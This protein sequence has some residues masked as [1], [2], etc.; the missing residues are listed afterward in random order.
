M[1]K[2]YTAYFYSDAEWASTAIEA[3][4]PVAALAA[5]CKMNDEDSCIL[6]FW[7]YDEAC[8]V[9]H[10]EILDQDRSELAHW[11]DADLLLRMAG[12]D[13]LQALEFCEMPPITPAGCSKR[14]VPQTHCSSPANT[15]ISFSPSSNSA[16]TTGS[17]RSTRSRS[18]IRPGAQ[19]PS[20]K[21]TISGCAALRRSCSTRC[22]ASTST[23]GEFA[24][25]E[26][27]ETMLCRIKDKARAA[28]VMAEPPPG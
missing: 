19:S 23:I 25:I 24:G 7:K 2:T 28:I 10:I 18:A 26:D 17:S 1:T 21:A 5:A 14:P 15:T 13:L 12:P 16:A 6:H 22:K 4:T 20:G 9:N 27:P 11:R 8:P 3:D